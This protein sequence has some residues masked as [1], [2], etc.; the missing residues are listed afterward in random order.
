MT[1]PRPPF[2]PFLDVFSEAPP[3]DDPFLPVVNVFVEKMREIRGSQRQ[4]A[5]SLVLGRQ[6]TDTRQVIVDGF[7]TGLPAGTP[8]GV[9][10]ALASTRDRKYLAL[11]ISILSEPTVFLPNFFPLQSPPERCPQSQV[12]QSFWSCR[13]V[14]KC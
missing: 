14:F 4:K 10:I 5:A 11:S 7:P 1:T 9:K 13:N 12:R 6:T 2:L 8:E 3:A